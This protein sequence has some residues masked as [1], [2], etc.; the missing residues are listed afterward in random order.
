[1]FDTLKKRRVEEAAL[2]C[3]ELIAG[4]A[5]RRRAAIGC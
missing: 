1:V 5:I 4:D 3:L 2:L